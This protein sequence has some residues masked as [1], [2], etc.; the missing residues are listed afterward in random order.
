MCICHNY[1]SCLYISYFCI[2]A[3]DILILFIIFKFMIKLVATLIIYYDFCLKIF[4]SYI[5][6]AISRIVLWNL[7]H[8]RN[9]E[10]VLLFI[11]I[12][13]NSFSLHLSNILILNGFDYPDWHEQLLIV[14]GCLDLD[15]AFHKSQPDPSTPT[16]SPDQKRLYEKYEHLI[17]YLS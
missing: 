15:L 16:S 7:H 6:S 4:Y 2:Y 9:C 8:D 3:M 5:I 10:H 14:L 17:D 13:S 1:C 11:A 12:T